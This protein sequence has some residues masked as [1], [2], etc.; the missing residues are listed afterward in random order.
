MITVLVV[1]VSMLIG[2]GMA[3][4]GK[5]GPIVECPE[6]GEH[7]WIYNHH[8]S[9]V[10]YFHCEKCRC[11]KGRRMSHTEIWKHDRIANGRRWL[12]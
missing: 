1:C 4:V 6:G 12:S 5:G 7:K 9:D 11:Y 8:V 3:L 2:V 10:A